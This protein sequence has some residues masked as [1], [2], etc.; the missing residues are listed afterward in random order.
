MDKK[1]QDVHLLLNHNGV[2]TELTTFRMVEIRSIYFGKDII[3]I[4]CP[5]GKIWIPKVHG[6]NLKID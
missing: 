1:Y 3:T 6:I 4:S 2:E 5:E